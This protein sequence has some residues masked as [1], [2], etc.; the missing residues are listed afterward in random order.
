MNKK[1]LIVAIIVLALDQISKAII[2]SLFKLN[3][4]KTIIDKL[5]Y[6]TSVHNY[7]V[8]WGL[9]SDSRIPIIIITIIA[10]II[11]YHFIYCFKNNTRNNIAFGLII[12]GLSGNL[13]DR[14]LLGYVRDFLDF[15]IYKYDYPVFN[16]ADIAIVIGVF[17]L[18]IA[19]IKGEDESEN[20][21][22]RNRDKTRQV[23]SK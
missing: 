22:T 6:I 2:D 17:L 1:T 8:A 9:F 13:I 14:T 3:V 7:G 4:S 21:S 19:I 15:M 18:I 23:S 10:L 11:I 20:R 12:G 5:F 16:I